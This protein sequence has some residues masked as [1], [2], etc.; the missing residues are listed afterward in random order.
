MRQ[1]N[2][3]QQIVTIENKGWDAQRSGRTEADC[4][5]KGG[6][7][8]HGPGGSLQRQRRQAWLRGFAMAKETVA[9]DR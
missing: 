8:N 5:Y 4:P 2:W 3:N 7:W 1:N 6:E 9:N